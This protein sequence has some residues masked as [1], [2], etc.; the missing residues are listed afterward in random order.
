MKPHK[1]KQP[2]NK[3][4]YLIAVEKLKDQNSQQIQVYWVVT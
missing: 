4:K 2:K 3:I 1:E